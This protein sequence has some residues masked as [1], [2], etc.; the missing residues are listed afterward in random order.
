MGFGLGPNDLTVGPLTKGLQVIFMQAYNDTLKEGIRQRICTTVQS[1]SDSEDYPFLGSVPQVREFIG[2]RQ[3]KDLANYNY[4]I[5]N[6]EWENSLGIR[7]ADVENQKFGMINIQVQQLA[8]EA[9]RYQDQIVMDFIKGASGSGYNAAP[10]LCYDG[11]G[12]MDTDHPAPAGGSAQSNF[13]TATAA[14]AL[15]ATSLWTGISAM[16]N[17]RNDNNVPMNIMPDLLLVEPCLEQT[18]RELLSGIGATYGINAQASVLGSM[19]IDVMVSPFLYTTTTAANGSW[20]LLCTK[21]ALKPI[22]FQEHNPIELQSKEKESD[23]AF[24]RN[25]YLYGTYVSYNV[26]AGPWF[27]IYGSQGAA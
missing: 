3:F 16:R 21:R 27:T 7:R 2:D 9:A 25:Q 23:S 20:Y 12:F 15:S 17:Y 5:K 8:Q 14:G 11:Q 6:K 1:N 19:G 18:A 4:N 24:M 22:I 13:V 10:Y 26:G